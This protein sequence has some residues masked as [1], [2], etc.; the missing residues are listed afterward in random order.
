MTTNY[1]DAVL[2]S[3]RA[4]ITHHIS[5]GQAICWRNVCVYLKGRVRL[6]ITGSLDVMRRL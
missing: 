5:D 4:N 6:G 2:L 1:S 3:S